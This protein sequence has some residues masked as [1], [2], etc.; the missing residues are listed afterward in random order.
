[1]AEGAPWLEEVVGLEAVFELAFATGFSFFTTF[2]S[3]AK[4]RM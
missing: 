4:R 1:L 3:T 2:L